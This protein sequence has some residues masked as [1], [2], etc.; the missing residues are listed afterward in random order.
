M[1]WLWGLLAIISALQVTWAVD[2]PAPLATPAAL[3]Y[4]EEQQRLSINTIDHEWQLELTSKQLLGGASSAQQALFDLPVFYDGKVAGEP[5]SWVRLGQEG[6]RFSGHIYWRDTLYKLEF[7]EDMAVHTLSRLEGTDPL[8]GILSPDISQR[9]KQGLPAITTRNAVNQ[10]KIAPRAV[11]IGIVIDSAFNEYHRGRGLAHALGVIN[12]ADGLYQEQL[13]LA[14]VVESFR[15]YDDPDQDPLRNFEGGVEQVLSAFRE[16]RFRDQELPASLGLVHLFSGINDPDRK[17][18]LGWIDTVC[19]L[20]GYDLSVSTPFPYDML[21]AAHEIAHNLGAVHDDDAQCNRDPSITGAE[22]MWSELSGATRSDFSMCSLEDMSQALEAS[23]V[24]DNL[25]IG[26]AMTSHSIDSIYQQRVT[27]SVINQDS[28]RS[29][30][31]VVSVTSFPEGTNLFNP[32]ADCDIQSTQLV[33]RHLSLAPGGI[34][35]SSVI[36]QFAQSAASVIS[37]LQPV[38]FTDTLTLDNRATLNLMLDDSS[39][40]ND[41]AFVSEASGGALGTVSNPGSEQAS[42]PV[43]EVGGSAGLTREPVGATDTWSLGLLGSF[44]LLGL[45]R[46]LTCRSCS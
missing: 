38:N 22:V 6:D 37:E 5:E 13:G 26:V 3:I 31:S 43:T 42:I 12:G 2:G 36:A 40:A 8:N 1:A 29:A 19:R 34:S 20:D 28:A 27:V 30:S 14:L 46:R 11:R 7:L 25:N 23:C 10:S 21:L 18:G 41:G 39:L 32:T 17:I 44:A 24:V 45:I 9:A 33:C 35:E 16:I 4:D 15:V